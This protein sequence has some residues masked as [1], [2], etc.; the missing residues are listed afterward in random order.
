MQ[1]KNIITTTAII[2]FLQP[3]IILFFFSLTTKSN[4]Q[5]WRSAEVAAVWRRRCC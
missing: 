2:P 4:H 3:R 1:T 5:R